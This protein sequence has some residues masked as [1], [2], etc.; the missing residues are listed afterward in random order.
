MERDLLKP[1]TMIIGII[2]FLISAVYT[3]S[4]RFT[5]IFMG[6]GENFGLSMGFAFCLVFL[7]MFVSSVVAITPSGKE[8]KEL[9]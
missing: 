2:G 6:L 9:K 8:L 1:T 4:G 7:I 3:V 5:E